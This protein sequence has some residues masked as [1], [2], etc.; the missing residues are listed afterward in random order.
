MKHYPP[1]HP[2]SVRQSSENKP[3]TQPNTELTIRRDWASVKHTIL[4]R[5]DVLRLLRSLDI[6]HEF[7]FT[8]ALVQIRGTFLS[9]TPYG[10]SDSHKQLSH[11]LIQDLTA[12]FLPG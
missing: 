2:A 4:K 5:S 8:Q 10:L 6:P 1:D 7:L 3:T 9:L 12:A 11:I